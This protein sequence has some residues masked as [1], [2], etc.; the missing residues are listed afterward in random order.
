[1][2]MSEPLFYVDSIE[3]DDIASEDEVSEEDV[4]EVVSEHLSVCMFTNNN[5]KICSDHE[6]FITKIDL[7]TIF[8]IS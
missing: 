6:I 1:M 2:K 5:H 3:S 8:S 4:T 7:H